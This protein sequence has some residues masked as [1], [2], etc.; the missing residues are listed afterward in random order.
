VADQLAGKGIIE[1]LSLA[2]AGDPLSCY[3]VFELGHNVFEL[4]HSIQSFMRPSG[5]SEG[6]RSGENGTIKQEKEIMVWTIPA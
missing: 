6:Q 5:V 4:R 2:I 1:R 3:I